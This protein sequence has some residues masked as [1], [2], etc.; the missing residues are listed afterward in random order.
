M[1]LDVVSLLRRCAHAVFLFLSLL[2]NDRKSTH[3][4]ARSPH[5]HRSPDSLLVKSLV[6][7]ITALSSRRSVS[8]RAVDVT[9]P[10]GKE[11][12]GDKGAR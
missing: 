10:D 12:L 3:L 1:A 4:P 7:K 9:R 6:I 11:W 5:N 2:R 8:I